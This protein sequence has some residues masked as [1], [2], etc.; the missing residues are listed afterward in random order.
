M[1]VIHIYIWGK[2][3]QENLERKEKKMCEKKIGKIRKIRT[4]TYL[5]KSARVL[6]VFPRNK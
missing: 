5:D 6:R 1:Y 4:G 2:T 3:D